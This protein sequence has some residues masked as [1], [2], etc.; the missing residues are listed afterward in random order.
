MSLLCKRPHESNV[1]LTN[2]WFHLS[3]SNLS[4][5]NRFQNNWLSIYFIHFYYGCPISSK[6]TKLYFIL[7]I[8]QLPTG[9]KI[10]LNSVPLLNFPFN[11][12]FPNTTQGICFASTL[13]KLKL[14]TCYTS[15]H[16]VTYPTLYLVVVHPEVLLQEGFLRADESGVLLRYAFL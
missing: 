15:H 13:W 16:G 10:I 2:V 9:L 7:N 6:I 11:F 1:A 5:V 14:K 4:S 3:V 12:K 8:I